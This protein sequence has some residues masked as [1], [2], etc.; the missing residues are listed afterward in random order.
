[1]EVLPKYLPVLTNLDLRVLYGRLQSV[2]IRASW[3]DNPLQ[4]GSIIKFLFLLLSRKILLID[5][6]ERMLM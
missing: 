4:Y 5:D 3:S 1:M 2:S 6:A